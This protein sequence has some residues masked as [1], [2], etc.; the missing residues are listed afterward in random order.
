MGTVLRRLIQLRVVRR[1]LH[2]LRSILSAEFVH[3]SYGFIF[4]PLDLE[5][6]SWPFFH[7]NLASQVHHLAS[8]YIDFVLFSAFC[9]P[10]H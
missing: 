2:P 4:R 5:F 3:Q 1:R 7:R 10:Q 9:E 8:R 6:D